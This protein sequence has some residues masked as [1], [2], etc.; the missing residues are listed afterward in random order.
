MDE[1]LRLCMPCDSEATSYGRVCARQRY[2]KEDRQVPEKPT[3]MICCFTF[4]RCG[5]A[6]LDVA[7]IVKSG[8][9][10]MPVLGEQ[11]WIP[12]SAQ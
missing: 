1:Q 3:G 4:S 10:M 6:L 8:M 12:L 11:I 9:L 2:E 7:R 5:N